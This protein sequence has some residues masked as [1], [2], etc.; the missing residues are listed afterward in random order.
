MR[1]PGLYR[2]LFIALAIIM[3]IAHADDLRS[4]GE[5]SLQVQNWNQFTDSLYRYH[6]KLIKDRVIRQGSYRIG[7]YSRL[8]NFYKEV[9][10]RDKKTGRLKSRIAW[11]RKNPEKIH[12]IEIFFYDKGGRVTRDYTAAFLPK[13]RNAPIQ[14][15]ISLHN[16]TGKLHGFRVFDASGVRIYEIC[17]GSLQGK[18]VSISMDFDDIEIASTQ[19]NGIRSTDQ[20][21]ACF[22]PLR[23]EIG[24]LRLPIERGAKNDVIS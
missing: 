19:T 3:N 8:P 21:K 13:Y 14:A 23:T 16:Y 11:E 12:I 10:Y 5:D 20:Y 2:S 18:P 6:K 9:E 7:G 4:L 22:G 1:H 24:N 17:K 15:L